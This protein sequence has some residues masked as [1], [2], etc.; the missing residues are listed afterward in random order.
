M[1]KHLIKVA[2]VL[3]ALTVSFGCSA[4]SLEN[5]KVILNDLHLET[6]PNGTH[7]VVGY[8]QNKSGE[9]LKQNIIKFNLL[10]NGIV[11][12]QT[13]DVISGIKP[14]QKWKIQAPV[15]DVKGVPDTF[16]VTEIL[17]Y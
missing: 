15:N 5:N 2:S 16:D 14:N 11:V 17:S 3:V 12:S 8:G 10:Q 7:M 9:T 6:M 4:K 1:N 13:V